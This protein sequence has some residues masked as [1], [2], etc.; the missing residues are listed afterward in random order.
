MRVRCFTQDD[1]HIFMT[2]DQIT[3]EIIGVLDLTE[4]FYNV[5]GFKFHVEVST[6]PEDSMGTDE[7]WERATDALIERLADKGMAV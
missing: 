3:D 4:Y 6:R 2:M 5:F 1:A 7:Q